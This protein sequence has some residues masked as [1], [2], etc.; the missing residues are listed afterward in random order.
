MAH[1]LSAIF[2]GLPAV[3]LGAGMALAQPQADPMAALAARP[4]GNNPLDPMTALT[5]AAQ[6]DKTVAASHPDF[7][8]LPDGPGAEQTYYQCV[9]CHSTQIIIQQRIT[10]LRW[11][12]LWKWMVEE[13]GMVEPE[14]ETKQII[15]TYLKQN[16][17][18]ER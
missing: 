4:A 1:I 3:L 14:P 18:S 17:S 12:E 10:D 6:P 16:F 5:V 2:L 13:Q 9:A 8:G 15:L 7:E 11:D